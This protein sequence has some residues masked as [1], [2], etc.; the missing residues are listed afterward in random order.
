MKRALDA[1]VGI[2]VGG[3][4]L[5]GLGFGVWGLGLGFGVWGLGFGVWGLG[6]G[7]W[8]LG[9]M[10]WDSVLVALSFVFEGLPFSLIASSRFVSRVLILCEKKG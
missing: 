6:C 10:E 8:G 5:W 4:C 2:R 3:G 9:F 7:V 1:R